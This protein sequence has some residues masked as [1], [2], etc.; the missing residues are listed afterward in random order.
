MDSQISHFNQHFGN[1][2]LYL[3]DHILKNRFDR[4]MKVLDAGCGEGRNLTY[5]LN[6]GYQVYALDQQKKAID[7]LKFMAGTIR[8]DLEAENFCCGDMAAMPFE[9][10][11]FDL[12]ICSAVLHFA[13]DTGHFKIM[14]S[15]LVRCLNVEGFLFIRMCS[16][17]GLRDK[18]IRNSSG[19]SFLPDG[20]ERFL[21]TRK[22]A[23]EICLV[24]GLS[25]VEPLKTVNVNDQRAMS[26]LLLKKNDSASAGS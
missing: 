25:F 18:V 26:T 15:E 13:R 8:P 20:T 22:L 6:A 5:F 17:I 7:I 1:L 19:R 3:L 10:D 4:T 14:F 23:A 11:Q 2:D 24:H 12:I 16:D 21:L 9:Q